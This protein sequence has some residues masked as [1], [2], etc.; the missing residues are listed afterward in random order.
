MFKFYKDLINFRGRGDPKMML[1]CINPAEAKLLDRATGAH[2]KFRLGGVSFD[3]E[4]FSNSIY[5]LFKLCSSDKLCICLQVNFPPNIYYKVF[6]HQ[7]IVD[8]CAYSP[9]DY[10]ALSYKQKLPR[11][12]HN[13][14]HGDCPD[15]RAPDH[16]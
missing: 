5:S 16:S 12:L 11:D 7:P 9:R 13:H 2:I 8:L 15:G 14:G 10:T 1:H 4:K 6:T 3:P